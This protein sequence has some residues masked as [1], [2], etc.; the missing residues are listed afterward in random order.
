MTQS[1]RSLRLIDRPVKT[2]VM[3]NRLFIVFAIFVA[4]SISE[5]TAC[6]CA[7]K[8]S[9]VEYAKQSE[10]VIRARIVSYGKKLSHGETLFE[11]MSVEI[12]AVLKGRLQFESIQLMGDPGHLCR[13]YVDS[14]IFVV[15]KEFLIALHGDEA[16]QPFGG[17]GEAWIELAGGVAKGVHWEDGEQR[18]YSLQLDDLLKVL[19]A[20]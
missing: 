10:G 5:A 4:L 19:K 2:A 20:K 6:S 1:G 3:T 16:V 8:G 14:R 17:C 9:F 11:S 15:G 12:I 7:S 18:K 13:D